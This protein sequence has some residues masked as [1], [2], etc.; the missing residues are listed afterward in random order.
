MPTDQ[1]SND[2]ERTRQEPQPD[3]ITPSSIGNDD[4]DFIGECC[5]LYFCLFL[6]FFV[7]FFCFIFICQVSSQT[8]SLELILI[9]TSVLPSLRWQLCVTDFS[10]LLMLVFSHTSYKMKEQSL[11]PLR[12]AHKLVRE[13]NKKSHYMCVIWTVWCQL[14]WLCAEVS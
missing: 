10:M 11:S 9:W 3:P 4:R 7:F 6:F 5:V 14:G 13:K 8:L 2:N 1:K 12:G